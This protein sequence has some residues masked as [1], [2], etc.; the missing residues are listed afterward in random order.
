MLTAGA[1]G[2]ADG[3]RES[4]S[5]RVLRQEGEKVAYEKLMMEEPPASEPLVVETPPGAMRVA[6]WRSRSA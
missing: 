4:V 2:A 3:L 6:T 5:A 1:G